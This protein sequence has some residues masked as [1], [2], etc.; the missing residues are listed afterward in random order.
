MAD[1]HDPA[2]KMSPANPMTH[3]EMIFDFS[4]FPPNEEFKV[5][6]TGPISQDWLGT[7]KADGLGGAQLIWRT[8]AVGDYSL[9]A[10]GEDASADADFTVSHQPGE[11]DL[12]ERGIMSETEDRDVKTV[13]PTQDKPA[14]RKRT[15]ASRRTAAKSKAK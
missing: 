12:I 1:K 3:S 4:D 7:L 6:I 11:E 15:T 2:V 5:M 8:Q 13:E 14:P 9:T 10:E